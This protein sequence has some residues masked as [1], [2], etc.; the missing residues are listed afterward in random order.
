L[1][2]GCATD[3][4]ISTGYFL[5]TESDG[6]GALFLR[7]IMQNLRWHFPRRLA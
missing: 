7:E 1:F 2:Q 6:A 5:W 3:L 4:T